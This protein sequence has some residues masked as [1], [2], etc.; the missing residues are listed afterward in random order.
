M[1]HFSKNT[2][3]PS[4]TKFAYKGGDKIWG[5]RGGVVK[6]DEE[7]TI[8]NTLVFGEYDSLSLSDMATDINGGQKSD[9]VKKILYKQMRILLREDLKSLLKNNS[10]IKNIYYKQ[11][12]Y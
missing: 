7:E 3:I 5:G 1:Q 2:T 8:I 6:Q 10:L 11:M 9:I 12:L 4:T